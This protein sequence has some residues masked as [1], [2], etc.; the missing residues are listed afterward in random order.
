MWE[1][2]R[3]LE[4]PDVVLFYWS[5]LN[6]W[7]NCSPDRFKFLRHKRITITQIYADTSL[8]RHER[9]LPPGVCGKAVMAAN[10]A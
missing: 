3:K 10:G 5:P 1:R 8:R 7:A 4:S 9:K 6:F 2:H